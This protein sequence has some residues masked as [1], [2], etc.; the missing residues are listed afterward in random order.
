MT[1]SHTKKAEEI[2]KKSFVS[3]AANISIA[4]RN[5]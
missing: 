5:M 4:A 2:S 3:I 1:I